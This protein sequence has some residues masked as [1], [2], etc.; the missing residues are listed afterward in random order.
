MRIT[1]Q[2]VAMALAL[3]GGAELRASVWRLEAKLDRVDERVHAIER[4]VDNMRNV[5]AI[6]EAPE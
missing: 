2:H 5:V 1:R 4:Q 6:S 3:M